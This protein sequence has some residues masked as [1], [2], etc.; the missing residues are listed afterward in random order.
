MLLIH[1]AS[2]ALPSLLLLLWF[3]G[4]TRT[5]E[6]IFDTNVEETKAVCTKL[7]TK[8][9]IIDDRCLC[10]GGEG[11]I[12]GKEGKKDAIGTSAAVGASTCTG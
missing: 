6:A 4:Q 2:Y 11:K 10:A 8:V 5:K 7:K 1:C 3:L 12:K 9:I